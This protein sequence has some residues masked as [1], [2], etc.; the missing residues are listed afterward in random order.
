MSKPPPKKPFTPAK[1]GQKDA[2]EKPKALPPPPY[3]ARLSLADHVR[4]NMAAVQRTAYQH[5]VAM[6]VRHPVACTAEQAHCQL[7]LPAPLRTS[8]DA[9]AAPP[10]T[11]RHEAPVS[12]LMV[13]H[14][15]HSWLIVDGPEEAVAAYV[16]ALHERHADNACVVLV[17]LN[18][19][20][21]M[22]VQTTTVY[23]CAEALQ[24]RQPKSAAIDEELEAMDEG[25]RALALNRMLLQKMLAACQLWSEEHRPM[26][27][28]GGMEEI[29][30]V[31]DDAAP[32]MSAD[33]DAET[34]VQFASKTPFAAVDVGANDS[35][36]DGAAATEDGDD[37][38]V[39]EEMSVHS[40]GHALPDLALM[41]RLLLAKETLGAREFVG[42]FKRIASEGNYG[43]Q[44][45]PMPFDFTPDNLYDWGRYDINLIFK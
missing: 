9:A 44:V 8:V 23:R 25:E 43:E 13:H 4:R 1:R 38:E 5:R 28:M 29:G 33:G 7:Q 15:T 24:P 36:V 22:F 41:E 6:L 3:R 40:F 42:M 21:P 18:V 2:K 32:S 19:N 14:S 31:S 37:E 12:G 10:A 17:Q 11:A 20:R 45:W 39:E 26:G 35:L 34:A 16:A 27:G 30:S